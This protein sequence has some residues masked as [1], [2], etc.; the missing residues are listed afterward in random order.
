MKDRSKNTIIKRNSPFRN[1]KKS[2]LIICEGETE[3]L[4]FH[5]FK[6]QTVNL[7]IIEGKQGNAKSFV[8]EA[9]KIK[10]SLKEKYDESW[11]V[12]DKDNT[13][14]VDFIEAIK[15]AN[16]SNLTVAYSIIAFEVWLLLHFKFF[17]KLMNSNELNKELSSYLKYPYSKQE[18]ILQKIFKGIQDKED[19]AIQN[20]FKM[21]ER[22][23]IIESITF[24]N[25]LTTIH[26]LVSK[27]LLE[28][29]F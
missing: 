3:I 22:S 14:D 28:I 20:A 24:E 4:Y 12:L 11:C 1:T 26:L 5:R 16:Q 6:L 18:K 19:L 10:N 8:L 13:K 17:T 23:N 7:K 25:S 29:K 9:I 15:I 2:Y 27:I 21:N